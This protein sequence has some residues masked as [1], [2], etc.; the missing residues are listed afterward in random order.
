MIVVQ[1]EVQTVDSLDFPASRL[2]LCAQCSSLSLK[3]ITFSS[4]IREH[5]PIDGVGLS[6]PSSFLFQSVIYA[7]KLCEAVTLRNERNVVRLVQG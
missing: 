7:H 6:L 4:N 2:K 5:R 3:I 1:T